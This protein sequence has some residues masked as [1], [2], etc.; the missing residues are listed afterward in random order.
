MAKAPAPISSGP[1][2]VRLQNPQA[3][4]CN[5][6]GTNT[7]PNTAAILRNRL[8]KD[9]F[10]FDFVDGPF[11][12]QPA[13]GIDVIFNSGNFTWW[14][15][16]TIKGIR[17]AHRWLTDYIAEHG[18]YD[19]LIGFSQGCALMGSFLLYHAMENPDQPLPF[20]AAMFI[21]GGMPLY[22]LEDLGLPVSKRARQTHELTV[23]LL[24]KKAGALKQFAANTNQIQPGVG[25]WDGTSDL[26]HNPNVVPKEEDV[27]GLD[28]TAIPDRARIRIPTVHV[29][30]AKDPRWPA[31]MQLAH[32]CAKRKM[33][34][35]GGG[36]DIP[37]TTEVASRLAE[38]V[39]EIKKEI[40]KGEGKA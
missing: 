20:K 13:P 21:C 31:S 4:S 3:H 35:H 16:P 39:M 33:Y 30:G 40:E 34:D 1:K 15:E 26:L 6:Q 29:Y 10:T 8:P 37:R 24:T 32:F 28:F 2:Q 27:F 5:S 11:P 36:H 38:L 14:P 25:L 7:S 12:C 18:P 22:V 17:D 19:I 23:K 9:D